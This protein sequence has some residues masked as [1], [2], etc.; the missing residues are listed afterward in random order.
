MNPGASVS[1]LVER[2]ARPGPGSFLLIFLLSFGMQ[3]LFMTKVPRESILPHTRWELSA[4]AVSLA[5]TGRFADPYALP[6]GPTAHLP[7]AMPAAVGWIYR[8]LGTTLLAGY[9]VWLVRIAIHA[10]MDAMLPAVAGRLGVGR[11][12]GVLAGLAG[13][14]VPRWPGY[15]EAPTAVVVAFLLIFFVR[16][17]RGR[18]ESSSLVGS[19]AFGGAWGAAF[20][21]QP[22]LLPVLLGCMLFELWWRKPR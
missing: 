18:P 19:M 20:H 22:A 11:P 21:L 15:V 9:V 7:P 12:A 2:L 1:A 6:T 10:A 17:W 8:L 4:V 3:C 16:R 13:A 14:L 5:E